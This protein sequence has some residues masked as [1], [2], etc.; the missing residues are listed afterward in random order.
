MQPPQDS[1]G[2]Y[3]SHSCIF[4]LINASSSWWASFRHTGCQPL[5]Q[6]LY[7]VPALSWCPN[8]RIACESLSSAELYRE[9]HAFWL[10]KW[11]WVAADSKDTDSQLAWGRSYQC[12]ELSCSSQ[13]VA[14]DSPC[15]C[16]IATIHLLTELS[17]WI[18]PN[19]TWRNPCWSYFLMH[20]MVETGK[21]LERTWRATTGKNASA[22]SGLYKT[23]QAWC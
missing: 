3:C 11:L 18:G 7:G 5:P 8:Q 17:D 13:A 15:T 2:Y 21:G 22:S 19:V 6:Q 20:S 10:L 1:S 16:L 23:V 14:E 4:A 12:Q 9:G